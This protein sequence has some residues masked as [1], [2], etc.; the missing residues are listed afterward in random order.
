M[1]AEHVGGGFG[2][3]GARPP[4]GGAGRDGGTRDRPAGHRRAAAPLPARRHRPPRADPAPAAPRRRRGRPAHVPLF[5]SGDTRAPP[6]EGSSWNRRRSGARH[7][8]RPRPCARPT[9]WCG[10]MCPR[11]SWM[12]AP[13]ECPG[14]YALESAWTNWPWNSAWTRWSCGSAT[15]RR[16]SPTAASRSAAGIWWSACARVPAA[17]GGRAA[18]R[19]RAPRCRTAAHRQRGGRG[20]RIRSWCRRARR[21]RGPL[22]D[23]G[24]VVRV[25]ATDIGTAPGRSAPGRGRRLGVPL[26]RVRIEVADSDIGF[27]PM[28]G[29][30]SRHRLM[31]LGR[32]RGVRAADR[33][34]GRAARAARRGRRGRRRHLRDRRRREPLRH[35]TLCDALRRGDRGH[36][37]R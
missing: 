26:D 1:L 14:M 7:V 32:A 37:H 28:A 18:I 20:R 35:A 16:P 21:P 23:G 2:S 19:A 29:G 8:R 3:K 15:S 30:S 24:F 9:E 11:P 12:R 27:A 5:P 17:S 10:S 22:P 34:A 13:G 25:N 36:G 31:G 33:P 6:G 4:R